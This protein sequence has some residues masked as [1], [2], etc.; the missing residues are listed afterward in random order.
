[1]FQTTGKHTHCTVL[2]QLHDYA[3]KSKILKTVK[4][5]W[6]PGGG[7]LGDRNRWSPGNI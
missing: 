3:G 5:H 1:M 2:F 7:G 6:L 4:E